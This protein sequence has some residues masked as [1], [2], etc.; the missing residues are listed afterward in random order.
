M[1]KGFTSSLCSQHTHL[2]DGP[3]CPS[4]SSAPPLSVDAQSIYRAADLMAQLVLQEHLQMF[5]LSGCVSGT[6]RS[7]GA[8]EIP[9]TRI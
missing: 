1:A 8:P 4:V 3:G 7:P 2:Y 5:T 9:S 6:Y